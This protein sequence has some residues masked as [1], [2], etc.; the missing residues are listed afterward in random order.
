MAMKNDARDDILFGRR[1]SERES[2]RSRDGRGRPG[3]PGVSAGEASFRGS[4]LGHPAR[5][6]ARDARRPHRALVARSRRSPRRSPSKS[7]PRP[8][9]QAREPLPHGG[10]V[11]EGARGRISEDERSRSVSITSNTS[12]VATST[13]S[14]SEFVSFRR[15]PGGS[16][17]GS[18]LGRLADLLERATNDLIPHRRTPAAPRRPECPKVGPELSRLK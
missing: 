7:Q 11:T 6:R 18:A 12:T 5:V 3:P 14:T 8:M 15:G 13:T 9:E 16:G 1:Q 17:P 4:R 10:V 2:R